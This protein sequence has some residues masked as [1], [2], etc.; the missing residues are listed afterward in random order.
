MQEKIVYLKKK[1][2]CLEVAMTMS[3]VMGCGL[4]TLDVEEPK[5]I[6]VSDCDEDID[7]TK[8]NILTYDEV[9]NFVLIN[10]YSSSFV[11]ISDNTHIN[12][13]T[14]LK[15]YQLAT[16]I[17][18]KHNL[19]NKFLIDSVVAIA[20][21]IDNGYEAFNGNDYITLSL[22][23]ENY[24][25]RENWLLAEKKEDDKYISFEVDV[26]DDSYY[27]SLFMDLD[28]ENSILL[29]TDNV[30]KTGEELVFQEDFFSTL[31]DEDYDKN[32]EN[33]TYGLTKTEKES[34]NNYLVNIYY[35]PLVFKNLLTDKNVSR[36]VLDRKQTFFELL[37]TDIFNN[38]VNTKRIL[39]K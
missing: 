18:N 37:N 10:G 34:L 24:N 31:E 33:I 30:D 5:V 6:D 2:K 35:N 22:G 7:N 1:L 16:S 11:S 3:L 26:L 36:V 9:R 12:N 17:I 32:Y 39:R 27:M 19:S 23:T 38:D 25:F 14:L 4:D 15:A 20:Y 8:N 13:E 21:L 29:G 28:N